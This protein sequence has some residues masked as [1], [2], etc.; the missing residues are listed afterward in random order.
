MSKKELIAKTIYEFW[1]TGY[2]ITIPTTMTDPAYERKWMEY[3]W[4]GICDY[5]PSRANEC[6]ECAEKIMK[7]LELNET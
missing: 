5:N 6:R 1:P 3:T 7:V 4:E 2:W